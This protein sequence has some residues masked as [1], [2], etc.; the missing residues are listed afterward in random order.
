MQAEYIIFFFQDGEDL[1]V[2]TSQELLPGQLNSVDVIDLTQILY[3]INFIIWV[4]H[5]TNRKSFNFNVAGI[6][7]RP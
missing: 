1:L 6:H 7:L 3:S 2:I 5:L 4:Y